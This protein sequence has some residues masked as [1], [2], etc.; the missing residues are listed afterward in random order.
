MEA[1]GVIM[2]TLGLLGSSMA[3]VFV[4]LAL[5][6]MKWR[7]TLKLS[8]ILLGSTVVCCVIGFIFYYR[9][10]DIY[11]VRETTHLNNDG[12][13][14]ANQYFQNTIKEDE[15]L[16]TENNTEEPI[17]QDMSIGDTTFE[18]NKLN[19]TE[20]ILKT[21]IENVVG[22]D[23]L[24]DYMYI[25]EN[26]YT[27]IVFKG[28]DSLTTNLI[29]E[30]A[31]IDIKDILKSIQTIIDTDVRICVTFPIIDIYG[32]SQ[33]QMVIKADYKLD[34]IKKINFDNFLSDNVPYI[35]DVWNDDKLFRKSDG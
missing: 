14:E 9:G 8:F 26:N 5:V 22:K 16:K 31:Y 1:V 3:L 13:N 23:R 18:N 12:M 2:V 24:V 33:E 10:A 19:N 4:F 11:L 25:P 6:S 21:C 27:L 34:T 15:T 30:A 17:I 35:A 29:V 7:S 28:T 20:S 32:N